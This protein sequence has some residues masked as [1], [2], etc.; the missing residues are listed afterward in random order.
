MNSRSPLDSSQERCPSALTLDRLFAGELG[1][2]QKRALELHTASC[3]TCTSFLRNRR[4]GFDAFP[5][6]DSGAVLA[7]I[8][9]HAPSA[10]KPTAPRH[11][12]LVAFSSMLAVAALALIVLPS[13]LA[14]HDSGTRAKGALNLRVY[15]LRNGQSEEVSSGSPFQPG[16]RL[17]FRVS[18]P[19][20]GFVSI[21]G[22]EA[23]GTLY[24]AWPVGK[25]GAAA[26]PASQDQL[27]DGAVE[28]DDALGDETLWLVHC[29]SDD[30]QCS[31]KPGQGGS[32]MCPPGC[33]KAPFRLDKPR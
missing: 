30:A 25:S 10:A 13:A 23:D 2:E 1:F 8:E 20:S 17:R 24:S 5:Q 19:S 22:V 11:T 14:P 6:L 15:R 21:L 18:T 27:L 12:W 4:L 9:A 3:Q 16:D 7:K 33:T 32:L 28:L 29:A 26:L 31:L